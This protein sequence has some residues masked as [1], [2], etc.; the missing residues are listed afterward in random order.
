MIGSF[1][2]CGNLAA[3]V[4]LSRPQ[5]RNSINTMLTAL[6]SSDCLVILTGLLMFSFTAFHHTG[7][8][9][10]E[11]YFL[12]IYPHI[13]PFVYPVAL[14][15]QTCSAYLTMAVTVERYLAV[16]WPLKA[17]SICTIGKA[18][19]AIGSV[20]GFAVIYNIPR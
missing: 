10:F 17:R 18:K 14:T 2:L 16:C 19:T 6:V 12:T 4:T 11:T 5:M 1:G 9:V 8:V 20:A 3:I 7:W 15:A 13:V